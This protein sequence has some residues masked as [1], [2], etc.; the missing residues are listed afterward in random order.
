MDDGAD[1]G[2]VNTHAECVGGHYYTVAVVGP[3][4]LAFVLD[5]LVQSGMVVRGRNAVGIEEIGYLLGLG[6][7]THVYY[8][9]AG[10]MV[11][12]MFQFKL[13]VLGFTDHI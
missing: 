4:T 10:Y 8:G 9:G 3:G 13:F 5:H 1:I 6:A 12:Y 7:V 2:L 11:K